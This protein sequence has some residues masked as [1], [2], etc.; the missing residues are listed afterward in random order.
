MNK[1]T[2]GA[3]Q[4]IIFFTKQSR[5]IMFLKYVFVDKLKG[6]SA[7]VDFVGEFG[8]LFNQFCVIDVVCGRYQFNIP[9]ES[10]RIGFKDVGNTQV[11]LELLKHLAQ[12][13]HNFGLLEIINLVFVL[14][15]E[16]GAQCVLHLRY[17]ESVSWMGISQI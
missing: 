8:E 2:R 15:F 12:L 4:F 16:A 10:F 17:W 3:F 7:R 5:L 9:L 1:G 11:H 13:Y 14:G 6:P